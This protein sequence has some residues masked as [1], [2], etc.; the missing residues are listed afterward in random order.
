[1]LHLSLASLLFQVC[2]LSNSQLKPHYVL[3]DILYNAAHKGS[4]HKLKMWAQ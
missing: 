3:T 1:M 2:C 4:M